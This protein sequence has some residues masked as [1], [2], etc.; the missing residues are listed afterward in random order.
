MLV[1]LVVVGCCRWLLS[2]VVADCCYCFRRCLLQLKLHVVVC[3]YLLL[4]VC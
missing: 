2:L 3:C 4:F 1:V